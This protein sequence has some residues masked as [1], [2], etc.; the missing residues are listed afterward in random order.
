MRPNRPSSRA[1]A[2]IIEEVKAKK[3]IKSNRILL[4][5]LHSSHIQFK[6]HIGTIV[7]SNGSQSHTVPTMNEKP[8]PKAGKPMICETPISPANSKVQ[9][10]SG[11]TFKN[12][13]LRYIKV[14]P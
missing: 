14:S 12:Y 13:R 1:R 8:R 6:A 3:K 4:M 11:E 5:G 9:A 7:I 10:Q 2:R